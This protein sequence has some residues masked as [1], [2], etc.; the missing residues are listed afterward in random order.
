MGLSI[1]TCV[2]GRL[3][4]WENHLQALSECHGFPDAEYC[5]GLWGNPDPHMEALAIQRP[6][7]CARLAVR[8]VPADRFF[9]LPMA[10]NAA[11]A[12]ATQDRLLVLGAEIVVPPGTLE[13]A[14]SKTSD[15]EAWIADCI[16]GRD[17]R[18]IITKERFGAWPYCMAISRK[19]LERIG[20]WDAAFADGVVFDDVDLALR[21]IAS[22]VIFRW[23]HEVTV[24]HQWH[25]KMGG[26]SREGYSRRNRDIVEKR[27]GGPMNDLWPAWYRALLTGKKYPMPA[28]PEAKQRA[29][30]A[31]LRERGYPVVAEH[32][33]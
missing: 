2:S 16:D 13:W 23:D 19:A 17:G 22:G 15:D 4:L 25:P 21:L 10:Y 28:D 32:A 12:T 6:Q 26:A 18:P 1:L 14:A 30:A 11:L 9:P 20:G 7:R 33:A 3:E 29:L 27:W 5:L 24:V 8:Q 31:Q